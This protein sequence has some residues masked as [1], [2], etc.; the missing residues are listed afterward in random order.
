MKRKIIAVDIDDVIAAHA[1]AIVAY[2]NRQWGHSLATDD[3]DEDFATL[4]RVPVAEALR[5]VEELMASGIHSDF[6]R[7]EEAVPVL[8]RLA[9]DFD[10]I[11][12]TSRR[13]VQKALTEAWVEKHFPNIFKQVLLVGVYDDTTSDNAR[14]RLK[15]TKADVLRQ[16]GASYLIDDQPKHCFGA[17]KEGVACLLFGDYRWNRSVGPLPKGVVRVKTW[18]AVE[19]YFNAEG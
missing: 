16:L 12:V 11:A 5:R 1:E 14:H 17:A 10:L 8:K 2:S 15:T 4:W 6:Q 9:S 3:Y 7:Y 18:D 13:T 19:E